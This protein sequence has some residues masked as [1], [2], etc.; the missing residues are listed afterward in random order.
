MNKDELLRIMR[1]GELEACPPA[2]AWVTETEGTVEEL[3]DQC[4]ELGWM[5]WLIVGLRTRH[6][7]QTWKRP[8][9]SRESDG[10]ARRRADRVR[11]ETTRCLE[12]GDTYDPEGGHQIP[13]DQRH[14]WPT[15]HS[16]PDDQYRD[17]LALLRR[18]YPASYVAA[19][20]HSYYDGTTEKTQ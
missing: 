13:Y 8:L 3:W 16:M 7:P 12:L 18:E 2:L 4:E 6:P 10:L 11:R 9:D 20:I 19:L 1:G 14:E 15:H 17:A 5:V